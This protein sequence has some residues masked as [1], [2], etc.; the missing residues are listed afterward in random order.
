M[1]DKIIKILAESRIM[2]ISTIRPDGWP[3]TT[4]VGYA[5]QDIFIYFTVSRS[6]QKFSNIMH[7]DR[8][9]IAVGQD[10]HDPSSLLA[11]S[12]AAHAS[13]VRDPKQR[14]EIVRLLRNRHPGLKKLEFPS[15]P[16]AAVIRAHPSIITI[17][18]YS[19]GFGHADVLTVA[20]GGLTEMTAARPD[21]WGFGSVTK[22]VS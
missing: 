20:P 3:Q 5:H 21:D 13:E 9:S 22:D 2:A 19:K 16:N 11:I 12:M 17:S 10:F 6:S 8:V 4:I 7:D 14:D 1:K 15:S 18:D